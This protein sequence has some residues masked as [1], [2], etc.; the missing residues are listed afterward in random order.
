MSDNYIVK[1]QNAYYK[2]KLNTYTYTILSSK[3]PTD[4]NDAGRFAFDIP[5]FPYPTHQ[6][7]S[8]A[9]FKL[10]AYW[11]IG[12]GDTNANRVSADV[13]KDISGFQ[14]SIQGLGL[15]SSQYTNMSAVAGDLVV[16]P[17]QLF[18]VPNQYADIALP[19]LAVLDRAEVN[20]GTP[21][22]HDEVVISNPSGTHIVV[23]VRNIKTGL[24][25]QDSP[26]YFSVLKFEIE[27]INEEISN[28]S[29]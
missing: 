9:I 20:A 1:E 17:K 28:G 26:A 11:I 4:T 24:V 3:C 21:D 19:A 18:F 23:E 22:L 2:R 16:R 14:V 15:R 7:S 8:L 5:P 6:G 25:I 13:D 10:K 29:F 27:V 12:Q